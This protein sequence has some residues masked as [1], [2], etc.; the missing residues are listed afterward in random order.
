[1]H[2]R[3]GKNNTTDNIKF[4]DWN[5]PASPFRIY[6]RGILYENNLYKSPMHLLVIIIYGKEF[7]DAQVLHNYEPALISELL[8]NHCPVAN[9]ANFV[10]QFSKPFCIPLKEIE[11]VLDD[12]LDVLMPL[13]FTQRPL[14][15]NQNPARTFVTS[16]INFYKNCPLLAKICAKFVRRCVDFY[17]SMT[18]T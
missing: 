3:I 18:F 5:D 7:F 4:I 2:S 10:H 14:L 13:L 9:D 6:H 12:A 1:M 11:T 8:C 17:Q 16:I 15:F